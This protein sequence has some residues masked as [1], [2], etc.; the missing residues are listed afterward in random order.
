MVKRQ[1][2][3]WREFA[4]L[5][6]TTPREGTRVER[7]LNRLA[8]VHDLRRR[9]RRRTPR[10]VFDYVDGAAES[11][12]SIARSRQLFR[13]LEFAP[14]VLRNVSQVDTSTTLLGRRVDLPF[15]F[16]PTGFTRM[17]H[18][19]GEAAVARVAER[20]GIAYALSTMGTT[21]PEDVA[22]AAPDADRWFQLYVWRDRDVSL[23]LVERAK[24][25]GFRTLILTVDLPVLGARLRDSKNGLTIP[26]T[27]TTRT[28]LD[29]ALHPNWWFNFLT[30]E[31]LAFAT[32]NEI[33]GTMHETAART[34]DPSLN[35]DDLVWLREQWDGPIVVKGI[36]NI[37][38]ARKV[39]DLGVEGIVLSNH[40]GRQLDRSLIPLRLIAPT[41]AELGDD[42]EVYI[43]GGIMSG[44]DV[45][46]GIALG[47][48]SCFVGRAYLYGLMAGGERGVQRM[49]D[50]FTAD[51][52]R[53]MQLLGVS[54]ISDLHPDLVHLPATDR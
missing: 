47:A 19:E 16:A 25:S 10:A 28:F 13:R 32:L 17:M 27:L 26:P 23:G 11:E 41:V 1:I 37:E 14:H 4:P 22:T 36:Q 18:H 9:A 51:V 8:D 50:I 44:A 15:A 6:K 46:A 20:N 21:T 33:D 49:V 40:G 5:L 38:D 34:F 48:Q 43:D 12:I 30:T 29:G 3:R 2:P 42:A 24:A 54:S 7:S 39:V 35:F 52:E 53:T 45:V 31:P